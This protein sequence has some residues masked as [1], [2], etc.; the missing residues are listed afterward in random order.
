MA[1]YIARSIVDPAGEGGLADYDPGGAQ[2]FRDVPTDYWVYKHIEFVAD[3]G[4]VRGY[5]DGT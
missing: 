2:R 5:P 3:A 1:V 4:V